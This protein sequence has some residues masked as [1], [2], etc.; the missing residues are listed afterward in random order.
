MRNPPE[1][2]WKLWEVVQ[3]RALP[4]LKEGLDP[5][6]IKSL[7]GLPEK[8]AKPA[9]RAPSPNERFWLNWFRE[10]TEVNDSVD[11]LSHVV[12]YLSHYPRNRALRFHKLSESD[13]LRYHIE[14]YLHETYILRERL[15]RFLRK[16]QKLALSARDRS[17]VDSVRG[18]RATVETSLHSVVRIRGGHVHEHRFE[19]EELRNLDSIVFLMKNAKLRRLHGLRKFRYLQLLEKWRSQLLRNNKEARNLCT[20]VFDEGTKILVRNEPPR[21]SP[22]GLRLLVKSRPG[23]ASHSR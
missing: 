15:S 16:L 9:H 5:D 20:M 18:L 21:P 14:V 10:F 7:F 3:D 8:R 12:V 23:G 19:D 22:S 11:R 1:K 17:G 6:F 13:W 4:Y 2:Y